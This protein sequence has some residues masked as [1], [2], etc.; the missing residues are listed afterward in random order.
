M[1]YPRRMTLEQAIRATG[2]FLEREFGITDAKAG[3]VV[4][5]DGTWIE[6]RDLKT[7][8]GELWQERL[9][10]RLSPDKITDYAAPI[11]TQVVI[12]NF[13]DGD[14]Y[15]TTI[16]ISPGVIQTDTPSPAVTLAL[17]PLTDEVQARVYFAP[18]P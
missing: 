5:R 10:G 8:T 16:E 18:G 13:Y 1:R 2:E 11:T 4:L 9:L 3:A 14:P 17:V 6:F 12:V 15:P 7:K